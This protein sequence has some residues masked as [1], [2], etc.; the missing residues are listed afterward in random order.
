VAV[1]AQCRDIQKV[2]EARRLSE[3][4][5]DFSKESKYTIILH[6]QHLLLV[7][8]AMRVTTHCWW[9][10]AAMSLTSPP[11][12]CVNS[13]IIRIASLRLCTLLLIESTNLEAGAGPGRE[14]MSDW[15][16]KPIR[17]N[18]ICAT[19]PMWIGRSGATA[20]FYLLDLTTTTNLLYAHALQRS[21]FPSKPSSL[22][23]AWLSRHF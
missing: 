15:Q 16:R 8:Q 10:Q 5:R 22:F 14:R 19:L 2:V 7:F 13:M 23:V 21:F 12:R 9:R 3:T 17:G 6:F 4:F 18:G 20:I 1:L 11:Q